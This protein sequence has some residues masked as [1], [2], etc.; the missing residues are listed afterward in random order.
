MM[1]AS[2]QAEPRRQMKYIGNSLGL[3]QEEFAKKIRFVSRTYQNI[4]AGKTDKISYASLK[5]LK[6]AGIDPNQVLTG[7]PP[8]AVGEGESPKLN[9]EAQAMQEIT[10][11][12]LKEIIYRLI[13]INDRADPS[14][15]FRFKKEILSCSAVQDYIKYL[16][17]EKKTAR[18]PP[19]RKLER[20]ADPSQMTKHKE[21]V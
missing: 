7:S 6:D 1:G 21:M 4:E 20:A 9:Q 19:E 18:F 10:W 12:E 11:P 17:R 13:E 8:V 2:Y 14:L 3:S 5:A 15:R 16:K